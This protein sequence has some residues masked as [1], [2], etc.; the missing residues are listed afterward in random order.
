MLQG[1]SSLEERYAAW[2]DLLLD[3][4]S[5]HVRK[6]LSVPS[7]CYDKWRILHV[8]FMNTAWRPLCDL[9]PRTG[10]HIVTLYTLHTVGP[11]KVIVAMRIYCLQFVDR[12]RECHTSFPYN[13]MHGVRA[14]VSYRVVFVY[15][16]RCSCAS[17]NNFLTAQFAGSYFSERVCRN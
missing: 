6:C 10:G 9:W 14:Y 8:G 3:R 15:Y 13:R 7:Q 1:I 4:A 17:A 16:I 11:Y 2:A 12:C 5:V